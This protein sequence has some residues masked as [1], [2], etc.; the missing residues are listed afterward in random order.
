MIAYMPDIYPDELIYSWLSRWISHCSC[1]VITRS[2][3]LSAEFAVKFNEDVKAVLRSQYS[4][5]GTFLWRH[6]MIPYY[7]RYMDAY[8][9]RVAL[10]HL[11]HNGKI[12]IADYMLLNHASIRRIRYCPKCATEDR[13]MY[14]ESYYHRCHQLWDVSM[15]IKHGCKLVSTYINLGRA[16]LNPP[17][18][19]I[20][21]ETAI[22]ASCNKIQVSFSKYVVSAFRATDIDTDID[23]IESLHRLSA[24]YTLWTSHL[25]D[26]ERI[27]QDLHAFYAKCDVC[28][29]DAQFVQYV[30]DATRI[31]TRIIL[32]L[33]F[34]KQAR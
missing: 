21:N 6:T 15:C 12:D 7:I 23:Y 13:V 16:R 25:I 4:D 30:V 18:T 28:I 34:M 24:K 29:P 1:S 10:S 20:P 8:A 11:E 14:G 5:I 19:T 9:R 33:L 3:S 32:L 22:D 26:Y 2:R 31:D 27:A 17:D